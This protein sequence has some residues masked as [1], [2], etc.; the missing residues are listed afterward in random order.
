MEAG[1]FRI[2]K[3]GGRVY[4]I[5]LDR[6]AGVATLCRAVS[7]GEQYSGCT[8]LGRESFGGHF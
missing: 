2:D 7:L 5:Q 4:G 8:Y 6:G 3:Q 1:V